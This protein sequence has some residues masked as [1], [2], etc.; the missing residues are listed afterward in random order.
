MRWTFTNGVWAGIT[1]VASM[2]SRVAWRAT[3]WAWLPAD[4]ATTPHRRSSSLSDRS[5]LSAPRSL[6]AAVN[7]RFS[8]FSTMPVP[9]TSDSVWDRALGE[10]STA[11][12]IRSAAACTSSMVTSGA[13]LTGPTLARPRRR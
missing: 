4:I 1:M 7:C 12:A 6:N 8:N 13:A 3:A 2:P 9:S 11:P 5:L 10:R